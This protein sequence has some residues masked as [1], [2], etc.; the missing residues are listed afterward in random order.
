MPQQ[1]KRRCLKT[2]RH[3]NGAATEYGDASEDKKDVLVV[4]DSGQK[5]DIVDIKKVKTNKDGIKS[6]IFAPSYLAHGRLI[7]KTE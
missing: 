6:A 7:C 4:L 5:R 3:K 2:T 1:Q